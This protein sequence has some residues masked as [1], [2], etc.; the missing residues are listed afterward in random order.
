MA[1]EE[2]EQLQGGYIRRYYETG[3]AAIS[4]SAGPLPFAAHFDH[5]SIKFDAAPT[6]SENFTVTKDSKL[7][8][9]YDT[10]LYSLNLSTSSVTDLVLTRDDIAAVFGAG[11]TLLIEFPNTD[12]A[13][14]GLEIV[15]E[16]GSE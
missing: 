5:L 13:T 14:Y 6:T 9:A 10:L 4:V 11:D 7:G 16:E 15:F 3:S 8:A 2:R 1:T 12:T